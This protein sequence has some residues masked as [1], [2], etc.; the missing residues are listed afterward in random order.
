MVHNLAF[1]S[2]NA[3]RRGETIAM[4]LCFVALGCNIRHMMNLPN[5]NEINNKFLLEEIKK[6]VNDLTW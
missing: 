3:Q 2:E 6:Y 5:E 1:E 4:A